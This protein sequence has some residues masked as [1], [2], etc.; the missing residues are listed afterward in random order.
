[1]IDRILCFSYFVS[2]V[3][4]PQHNRRERRLSKKIRENYLVSTFWR[5][6]IMAWLQS[7]TVFS[8]SRSMIMSW[9][10]ARSLRIAARIKAHQRRYDNNYP[11][12]GLVFKSIGYVRI[13]SFNF[14]SFFAFIKTCTICSCY[15]YQ[16]AKL[17]ELTQ[18]F[19]FISQMGRRRV[20]VSCVQY[21]YTR[22]EYVQ[23][24]CLLCC[25]SA[26]PMATSR[27]TFSLALVML[28]LHRFLILN[29]LF[30]NERR[31]TEVFLYFE[32]FSEHIFCVEAMIALRWT[33]NV[34]APN[35]I[36]VAENMLEIGG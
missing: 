2:L 25:K 14:I 35:R 1:M 23:V 6:P 26:V 11:S 22:I 18:S 13:H 4:E 34:D 9:L 28:A 32:T 7:A 36:V 21:E 27:F 19:L 3:V 31:K 15:R 12:I 24:S 8:L 33:C 30:A 5:L 10:L 16:K 17:T 29:R 20:G